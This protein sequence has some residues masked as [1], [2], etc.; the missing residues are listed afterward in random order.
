MPEVRL[1]QAPAEA[2]RKSR[3][4][5]A[6]GLVA[7]S[8]ARHVGTVGKV[9]DSDEGESP[10]VVEVFEDIA[11]RVRLAARHGARGF[12][13]APG[14]RAADPFGPEP[15]IQSATFLAMAAALECGVPVRFLTEGLPAKGFAPLFK[16]YPHEVAGQIRFVGPSGSAL[17]ELEPRAASVE[18]RLKGMARLISTGEMSER[19]VARIDPVIPGLNDEPE[20][21]EPLAAGLEASGAKRA[22]IVPL[23]FNSIW[24]ER[25]A[26]HFGEKV[27]GRVSRHYVPGRA[28]KKVSPVPP[29]ERL[30]LERE[31][32]LLWRLKLSFESHGLSVAI[33]TCKDGHRAS[34]GLGVKT[35][36]SRDASVASDEQM[37]L[38]AAV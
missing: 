12:Y 15:H 35:P 37:P 22:L 19:V 27:L 33:C 21:L 38:W 5:C 17:E 1:V 3:F 28:G 14:I 34:C 16:R 11:D 23:R 24:R 2:L 18:A 26:G 30:P 36:S 13:F 8:V 4:A 9:I 6:S 31:T 29:G 25:I 10:E 20:F 32:S 7:V